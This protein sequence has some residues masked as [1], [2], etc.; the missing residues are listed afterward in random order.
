MPTA[1]NNGKDWDEWTDFLGRTFKAGDTVAISIV[2][3]KAADMVI[4][5]V[6]AIKR[7]DSKGETIQALSGYREVPDVRPDGTPYQR[8]VSVYR[9]SAKV[10]AQPLPLTRGSGSYWSEKEDSEHPGDFAPK[11]NYYSNLHNILKIDIPEVPLKDVSD[12]ELTSRL[13]GFVIQDFKS[14]GTLGLSRSELEDSL[15][16]PYEGAAKECINDLLEAGQI[17]FKN[18]FRG[19]GYSKDEVFGLTEAAVATI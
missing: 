14:N 10:Y 7:Q 5:R 6:V 9:D 2:S 4:A 11:A 17:E 1:I 8:R 19:H 18:R 13:L 15:V 12:M 16:W 3:G